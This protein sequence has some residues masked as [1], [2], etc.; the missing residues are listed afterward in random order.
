MMKRSGV[1]VWAVILI[2]ASLRA[3]PPSAG[4]PPAN[5]QPVLNEDWSTGKIDPARWYLLRKKW[6]DGNHG[7]VPENVWIEKDIV[8]GQKQN[9]LVCQADGDLYD[10]NTIG[11]QGKKSRVG[12]VIVSKSFFASEKL[13]VVN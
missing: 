10:G 7:V 13:E 6:G 4:S 1:A 5:S 12:G 2:S 8:A 9:V 11:E 3:A